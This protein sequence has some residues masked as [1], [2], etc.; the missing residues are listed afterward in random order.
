MDL[1]RKSSILHAIIY[2]SIVKSCKIVLSVIVISLASNHFIV[3]WTNN[4]EG[5]AF[6]GG[7]LGASP[8]ESPVGANYRTRISVALAVV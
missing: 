5:C 4:D 1:N 3:D 6:E 7:L 8:S 2:C